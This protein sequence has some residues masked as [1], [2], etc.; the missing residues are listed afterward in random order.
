MTLAK[1]PLSWMA[2]VLTIAA[3]GCA[4]R[5]PAPVIET[6]AATPPPAPQQ[7]PEPAPTPVEDVSDQLKSIVLH[8]AFDEAVLTSEDQTQLTKLAGVLKSHSSTNIR[9][10][11]HCDERGTEEYN[12]A[13]GQRRAEVAKKYLVDL[14]VDPK[15][16]DTLSYGFERPLD[17][18]H[19][20]E[21]WAK[22]RRDEFTRN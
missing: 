16:V 4:R 13:L 3:L 21:A 6:A 2:V 1:S 17:T 11:G 5:Q 7:A 20:E 9:V 19:L 18:R 15:R 10:V 12:L 22:N 14:G 8:F